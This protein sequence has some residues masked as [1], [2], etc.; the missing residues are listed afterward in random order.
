MQLG[1]APVQEEGRATR[2]TLKA[3]STALTHCALRNREKRRKEAASSSWWADTP[4]QV[5]AWEGREEAYQC[6]PSRRSLRR[7][8]YHRLCEATRAFVCLKAVS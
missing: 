4:K 1:A 7:P 6:S 2:L 5:S 8:T 3:A